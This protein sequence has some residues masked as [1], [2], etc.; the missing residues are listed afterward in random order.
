[1]SKRTLLTIEVSAEGVNRVVARP[2]NIAEQGQCARLEALIAL[3]LRLL[4]NTIREV[5]GEDLETDSPSPD[6]SNQ[7]PQPQ[8]PAG[9]HNVCL[10]RM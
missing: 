7:P 9:G 10:P 5:S 8:A 1:M 6:I 3:P 2:R 4:D